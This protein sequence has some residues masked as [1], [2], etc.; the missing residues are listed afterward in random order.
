LRVLFS[1]SLGPELSPLAVA[2]QRLV[3]VSE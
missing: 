2:Y 1:A 3:E